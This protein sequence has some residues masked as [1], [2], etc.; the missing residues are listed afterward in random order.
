MQR[1]L[2]SWACKLYD[3]YTCRGDNQYAAH[4][5]LRSVETD[6][7]SLFFTSTTACTLENLDFT[8]DEIHARTCA[9]KSFDNSK[10]I[11]NIPHDIK[12]TDNMYFYDILY[13]SALWCFLGAFHQ[14]EIVECIG[15]RHECIICTAGTF[16]CPLSRNVG[17]S[18][19]ATHYLLVRG[20]GSSFRASSQ[21]PV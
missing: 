21:Q 15:K 1:E 3:C 11:F 9:H 17:D 20:G 10:Y 8:H 19:D 6:F 18:A 13:G 12:N 7:R 2:G 4:R 16:V 5:S 14:I